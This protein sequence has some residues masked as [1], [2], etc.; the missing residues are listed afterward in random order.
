VSDPTVRRPGRPRRGWTGLV[1]RL[2]RP[3]HRSL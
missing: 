1:L 3:T 2:P